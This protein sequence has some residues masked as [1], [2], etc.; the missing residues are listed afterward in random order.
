MVR[1]CQNDAEVRLTGG[2]RGAARRHWSRQPFT[3]TVLLF[4]LGLQLLEGSAAFACGE[5]TAVLGLDLRDVGYYAV[6]L[7]L[8]GSGV[9]VAVRSR[10]SRAKIGN[11]DTLG[12]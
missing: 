8:A 9:V 3:W 7:L 5:P 2:S 6:G 4:C 10:P 11:T 12:G 1:S